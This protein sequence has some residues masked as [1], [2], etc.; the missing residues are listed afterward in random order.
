VPLISRVQFVQ[1][2]S[3]LTAVE[4][5]RRGRA[6]LIAT[7]HRTLMALGIVVSSYQALAGTSELTERIVFE[8]GD[9]GAVESQ[10]SDAAKAAILRVA[11]EDE[12]GVAVSPGDAEDDDDD[13]ELDATAEAE[14]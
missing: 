3:R 6:P 14:A 11:I 13:G 7:L 5:V 2:G 9:G 4:I 1:A 8:R 12:D 10:L